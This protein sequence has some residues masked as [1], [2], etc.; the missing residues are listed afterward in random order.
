M[1]AVVVGSRGQLGS[2]M[3][4][5]AP[6][7]AHVLGLSRADY[8]LATLTESD[9]TS[10]TTRFAGADV[11]INTSSY[12]AVDAAETDEEVAYAV[13][14]RAP[15][16][17]AAAAREV[18]AHFVHISTDYVFGAGVPRRPL[19]IDDPKHPNT[20]YGASKLAGERAVLDAHPDAAIV[21]TA[22][23]FTGDLQPHPDFVSTMLRLAREGVNPKVVNDQWG[24]PTCARDLATGLW[25]L[26]YRRLSGTFHGAS[27]SPTTWFEVARE[28]FEACGADPERVQPCTTAE[29]PRPAA[30]PEWSVLDT[31]TWHDADLPA[32]PEWRTAV[33]AAVSTKL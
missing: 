25:A 33:R 23:L 6:T 22:W 19:Q 3:T 32:F 17:L 2:A 12:T 14:A 28:T 9:L 21:R 8:D 5:L 24:N 16:L 13:N 4:H 29:F 11:V 7:G 30:R 10:L 1:R 18:G 27:D 15:E 31:S 26:A 20:V